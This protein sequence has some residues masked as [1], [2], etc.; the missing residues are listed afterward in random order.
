MV[1]D[2]LPFRPLAKRLLA[3]SF[4]EVHELEG[5][6]R[7]VVKELIEP[8]LPGMRGG[9]IERVKRDIALERDFLRPYLPRMQMVIGRAAPADEPTL[10]IIQERIRGEAL[11]FERSLSCEELAMLDDF[12]CRMIAMYRAT[13]RGD[14]ASG[15]VPEVYVGGS[16]L[17]VGISLADP[18][19]I[20]RFWLVDV[21]PL[22]EL[23]LVPFQAWMRQW[24]AFLDDQQDRIEGGWQLVPLRAHDVCKEALVHIYQQE[25]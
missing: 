25:C 4:F 2:C 19:R 6:E 22:I 1:V 13:F 17:L 7:F 3:G 14:R 24:L 16:A 18:A 10:F 9:A 15:K 8:S 20:R 21:Y 11:A 12:V 5:D 23:D